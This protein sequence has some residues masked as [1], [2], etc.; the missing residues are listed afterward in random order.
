MQ[1]SDS[2][3]SPGLFPC[4]SPD[5][6]MQGSDSA[7]S[8]AEPEP[9]KA[10]GTLDSSDTLSHADM[11]EIARR[12]RTLFAA[13]T[14]ALLK[15][16]PS[17]GDVV[18]DIPHTCHDFGHVKGTFLAP[19]LFLTR[20]CVEIVKMKRLYHIFHVDN[21]CFRCNLKEI[22]RSILTEQT[23]VRRI[24]SFLVVFERWEPNT[25]GVDLLA[26]MDELL[27]N[28]HSWCLE[29]DSEDMMNTAGTQFSY[30]RRLNDL[31]LFTAST[32]WGCY[33]C[34][35]HF[36]T[37]S[38][39][40]CISMDGRSV[41][42]FLEDHT[43]EQ[44]MDCLECRVYARYT[45]MKACRLPRLLIF[46]QVLGLPSH[47]TISNQNYGLSCILPDRGKAY[48]TYLLESNNW[49]RVNMA[50]PEGWVSSFS[51]EPLNIQ[52]KPAAIALYKKIVRHS[53]QATPRSL[54]RAE[55]EEEPEGPR[56]GEPDQRCPRVTA[57]EETTVWEEPVR[58]KDW[59]DRV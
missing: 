9:E 56:D 18:D 35:I 4:S 25:S 32:K 40:K 24:E 34:G 23:E 22:S 38:S 36:A 45:R 49:A 5:R 12:R 43:E 39:C 1:G 10:S 20:L 15:T 50:E 51:T 14:F 17:L 13:C 21:G 48:L 52:D 57:G 3:T 30:Q 53:V 7:T 28:I 44:N 42:K 58:P 19:L 37:M 33:S 8:P 26:L 46:Y 27:N 11:E 6:E 31:F 16:T 29:K 54:G 59:H 2:A 41:F 55:E 47:F